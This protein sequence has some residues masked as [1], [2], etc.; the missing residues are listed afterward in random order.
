MNRKI[1]FYNIFEGCSTKDN[2]DKLVEFTTRERPSILAISEAN[3]WEDGNFQKLKEFKDRTNFKYHVFSKSN[4]DF[5]LALFANEEIREYKVITQNVWHS[6]LVVKIGDIKYII[7]HLNPNQERD[8]LR[9]IGELKKHIN[10]EEKIILTGDFNSISVHDGYDEENLICELKERKIEKFIEKGELQFKVHKEIAELGLKDVH[11]L[12]CKNFGYS[13]PTKFNKDKA[14]FTKLRLDFF[15]VSE[16]LIKNVKKYEIL[17][18]KLTDEISDHYPIAL[19][20][21][22]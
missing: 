5:N 19:E 9:E 13:V 20:I 7:I 14:H 15:Y 11:Y 8:R 22:E 2:F 18:D 10:K 12:F 16:N 1:I 6:I 4:T 21:K 3:H 17:K